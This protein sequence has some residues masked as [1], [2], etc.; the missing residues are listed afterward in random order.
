MQTGMSAMSNAAA[1][2]TRPKISEMTIHQQLQNSERLVQEALSLARDHQER[3][4]SE[5]SRTKLERIH[6][7]LA[8]LRNNSGIKGSDVDGKNKGRKR[9]ASLVDVDNFGDKDGVIKSKA[10]FECS[11]EAGLRL[12]KRPRN[13]AQELKSLREAVEADCKAAQERNPL[14]IIDII[15]EFGQPV[16][17]CL[18]N[19]QE[20]RLPKLI[21][22]VQRG[23]PR[24]GGATYGFERPPMGWVDVLHEI[25][26]R[27]KR[28]LATA[29]ASSVGVA[30][31]LEAWA[32][33]ADA[34][35]NGSYL[36]EEH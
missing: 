14:L 6:N 17:T 22:R 26:T 35:I 18:L 15:E 32:R 7:T 9:Q 10:V 34:V 23:Y 30:A 11:S 8:A 1:A 24:K 2:P 27:F 16:V 19:I 28:A 13:E 36:S 3:A 33:E 12:A 5:Q 29:P 4:G 20:I 21:L 25:R 31:F